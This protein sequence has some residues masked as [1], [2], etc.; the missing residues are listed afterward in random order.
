[1]EN[2]KLWNHCGRHHK[3]GAWARTLQ[4]WLQ[5]LRRWPVKWKKAGS[6]KM[7]ELLHSQGTTEIRHGLKNENKVVLCRHLRGR[8]SFAKLT[9]STYQRTLSP[10]GTLKEVYPSI[11]Q[12]KATNSR[13]HNKTECFSGLRVE[14]RSS[15]SIVF[16]L[17]WSV[18]MTSFQCRFLSYLGFRPHPRRWANIPCC[19]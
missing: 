17:L 4:K 16:F 19:S 5:R 7:E 8:W 2:L 14:S 11:L 10:E 1:M 12:V 15:D 9:T 13:S 3:T 6:C 18:L